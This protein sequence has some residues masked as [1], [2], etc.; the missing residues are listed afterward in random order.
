M[1]S[2]HR[3]GPLFPLCVRCLCGMSRRLPLA[4]RLGF[5]GELAGEFRSGRS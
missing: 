3:D 2:T 4:G 1:G 5:K